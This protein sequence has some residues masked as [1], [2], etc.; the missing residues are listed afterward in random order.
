[1]DLS[2]YQATVKG[3]VSYRPDLALHYLVPGLMVEAT[4]LNDLGADRR[5]EL[6]DV[7]WFC[8]MLANEGELSLEAMAMNREWLLLGD[9]SPSKDLELAARTLLDAWVKTIRDW[10][11]HMGRFVNDHTPLLTPVVAAAGA[12]A[13]EMGMTLEQ[14]ADLNV[15]KLTDRQR[16]GVIRG[17]GDD[18]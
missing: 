2:N 3:F 1:M 13:S 10:P 4:E 14:I 12:V 16:R 17:S 8:A 7:L 18:R 15:A 6:G 9:L 5:K 11:D